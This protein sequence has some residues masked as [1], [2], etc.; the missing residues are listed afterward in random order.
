MTA[1]AAIDDKG[2]EVGPVKDDDPDG[3]KLLA[4]TDGLEKAAK[5]LNPLS[6]LAPKNIDVWIAIYDVAVRRS[7][8]QEY[9]C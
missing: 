7:K 8:C 5:L 2:L 4:S 1:S 6:T 3:S 9:S